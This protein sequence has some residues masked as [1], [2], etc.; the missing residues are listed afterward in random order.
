MHDELTIIFEYVSIIRET[1]G[2]YILLCH[3]ISLSKCYFNDLIEKCI[4][5]RLNTQDKKHLSADM[6]EVI[7]FYASAHL[8]E[9]H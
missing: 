7:K 9:K 2:V 8:F 6:K 1:K 4:P 5:T 3:G